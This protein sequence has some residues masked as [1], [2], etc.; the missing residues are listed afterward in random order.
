MFETIIT[1]D[2]EYTFTCMNGKEKIE[3]SDSSLCDVVRHLPDIRDMKDE[4]ILQW[5]VHYNAESY[6]QL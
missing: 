5:V 3:K 4:H 6:A 1:Y 2:I